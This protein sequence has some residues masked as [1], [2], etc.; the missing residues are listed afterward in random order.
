[1]SAVFSLFL[2]LILSAV[3]VLDS[4]DGICFNMVAFASLVSP[5]HLFK[6]FRKKKKSSY[7]LTG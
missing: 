1:M 3:S 5:V 7:H 6:F 2:T 4:W